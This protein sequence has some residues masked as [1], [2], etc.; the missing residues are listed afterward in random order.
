[1]SSDDRLAFIALGAM[2]WVCVAAV[3]G[4]IAYSQAGVA[5]GL[6]AAAGATL[7]VGVLALAM[8]LSVSRR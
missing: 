4:L 7:L 6:L 1:M 8:F 3:T 2:L 5:A